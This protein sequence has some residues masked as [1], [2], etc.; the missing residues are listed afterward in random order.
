M[1]IVDVQVY[2]DGVNAMDAFDFYPVLWKFEICMC[3]G[4]TCGG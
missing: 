1:W 2:K 3:E 4:R